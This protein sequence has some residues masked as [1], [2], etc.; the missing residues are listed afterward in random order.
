MDRTAACQV[1]EEEEGR[2]GLKTREQEDRSEFMGEQE[3][4]EEQENEDW[5][6][7]AAAL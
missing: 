1:W 5:D 6:S 4:K 3:C 2:E 7:L